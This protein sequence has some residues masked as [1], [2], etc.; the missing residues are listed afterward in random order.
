[1]SSNTA[2]ATSSD[3]LYELMR[4]QRAVRR[5]RPD[6]IPDAVLERIMQAATWAPTGGNQQPW[7]F[8]M[9]HDAATKGRLGELYAARWARFAEGYRKRFAAAPADEQR[10]HER[11]IAAGDH[12]AS[13]FGACPVV[14]IVCFNPD[15]MAITDQRQ[16]R[17]S[18][19]GGGSVYTAVQNFL[20]ACRAEGVGSVLTTLLCLD[21]PAVKTLLAI[22]DNW[23][24][25][26]ALPMGYPVGRGYGPIARRPV[27]ELF[28]RD[29]WDG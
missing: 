4:T 6:P 5:L 11:T 12:L 24:T 7:R 9:V 17:V 15:L 27:T 2:S 10:K 22:P 8:V 23:F 3:S 28:F 16:D 19:V 26:A 29:R 25:A 18:V 13:H 21:E 1:M 20:L 14:A